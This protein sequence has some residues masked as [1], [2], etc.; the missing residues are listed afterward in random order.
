M[1]RRFCRIS[2]EAKVPDSTTLVKLA[3]KYGP[4]LLWDGVKAITRVVKQLKQAGAVTEGSAC[5]KTNTL[6]RN[7]LDFGVKRR[8]ITWRI[9]AG[10]K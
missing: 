7:A 1:W 10:P 2:L 3:K 4:D 9:R 8:P 5:D 6:P